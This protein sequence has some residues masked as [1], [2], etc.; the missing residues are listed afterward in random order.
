MAPPIWHLPAA[1]G[2]LAGQLEAALV[3]EAEA[4]RHLAVALKYNEI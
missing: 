4:A 1:A 2:R 3:E